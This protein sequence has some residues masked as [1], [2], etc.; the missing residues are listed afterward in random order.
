[1]SFGDIAQEDAK[2]VGVGGRDAT[3]RRNLHRIVAKVR[4]DQV[5]QQQ[6][7]VGVGIGAH[8]PLALGGQL[9]QLRSQSA[10]PIEQ[11]LRPV[12]LEPVFQQLQVLGVVRVHG[13]GHLM[14]AEGA[15]DWKT[16]D[17]LRAGPAF[18]G[19]ED[20]HRPAW[21]LQVAL[22]A[23]PVLNVLDLLQH[24]VERGRHR[25]MHP[26]GLVALD[27]IGRPATAEQKLLQLLG[28]DARQ[29]GGVGDLIAI[30]VQYRQHH[31]IGGWIEEL[32]GVPGRGERPG[33]RLAIAD[34]A[35]DDEIGIVEHRTERMAQ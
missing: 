6:T 30:E 12:A 21:P 33:F 25:R 4:H 34:H 2:L 16:I 15:F 8:A 31:P 26:L 5:A 1:L 7:A 17:P 3:R 10:L 27:E 32:I 14:R 19:I 9:G 29:D 28:L 35:G 13:N 18:R 24:P 23:C 22:A 11:L 20:D